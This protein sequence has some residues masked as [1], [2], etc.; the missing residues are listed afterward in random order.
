MI[1]RSAKMLLLTMLALIQ[2]ACPQYV[3]TPPTDGRGHAAE[4]SR[5]E[6]GD[7]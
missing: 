2:T 1:L 4:D 7:A 6:S 3:A 5:A